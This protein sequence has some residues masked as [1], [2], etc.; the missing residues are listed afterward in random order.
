VLTSMPDE[1]C[2]LSILTTAK[3]R[4]QHCVFSK[5]QT[6]QQLYCCIM[7]QQNQ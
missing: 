2:T 4:F 6:Q 5:L 1:A 3:Q 7:H